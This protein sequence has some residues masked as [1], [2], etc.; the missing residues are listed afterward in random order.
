M[1]I[2]NLFSTGV[3]A[4]ILLFSACKKDDSNN[5]KTLGLGKGSISF[6]TS[7]GGFG[8]FSGGSSIQ[9]TANFTANGVGGRYQITILD[10]QTNGTSLKSAQLSILL[11]AGSNT[12]NGSITGSFDANSNADVNPNLIIA[13][14]NG[15]TAGEGY[16]SKTGSITITKLTSTEIEGTFSGTFEN[17]TENTTTE[18]TN[19]KFAGKFK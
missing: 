5:A 10:Y 6:N 8:N 3:L 14:S 18:V 2:T 1:K 9:S 11:K 15:T 4:S 16:S 12:S 13:S 17:Q 7:S 19:G